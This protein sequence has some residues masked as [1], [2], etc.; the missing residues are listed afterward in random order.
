M[1]DSFFGRASKDDVGNFGENLAIV[2]LSRPVR[3]NYQRPL[4]RPKRLGDKYPVVDLI[5]DLNL[6]NQEYAGFFLAQVKATS[7]AKKTSPHLRLTIDLKKYNALAGVPI[8]TFLIGVDARREKAFVIAVARHR[9]QRISKIPKDNDLDN[10]EVRVRIYKYVRE[11]WRN[12][13]PLLL[14]AKSE[15]NHE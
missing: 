2:C 11:F 7:K 14:R 12:H 6:A 9:S 4:F 8:P 3:R 10:E 13:R 5:V 15:F 1:P